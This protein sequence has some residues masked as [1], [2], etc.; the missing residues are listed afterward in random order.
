MRNI[1][2]YPLDLKTRPLRSWQKGYMRLLKIAEMQIKRNIKRV[3]A[4]KTLS[5]IEADEFSKNK[6]NLKVYISD[7]ARMQILI[8][9]WLITDT[10]Y[11]RDITHLMSADT[12]KSVFD[13]AKTNIAVVKKICKNLKN[14]PGNVKGSEILKQCENGTIYRSVSID[15]ENRLVYSYMPD[16]PQVNIYSIMF[17][18]DNIPK[19][20]TVR[21]LADEF[22]AKRCGGWEHE[23]ET[24][25]DNVMG[26]TSK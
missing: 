7:E 15:D 11:F 25:L 10:K 12:I 3:A 4:N 9:E 24:I 26:T 17:N 5:R 6:K 16:I 20:L 2:W 18:Y 1:E 22:R 19:N 21:L 13:I 23:G 14:N 8:Y